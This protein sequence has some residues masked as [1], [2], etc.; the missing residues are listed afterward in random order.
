MNLEYVNHSGGA[1]GADKCWGETGKE[2]GVTSIHYYHGIKTPHGNRSLT[3]KEMEEGWIEVLEANKVLKR[4][5]AYYKSLLS[6]NW[7][8]V[9]Y[10]EAIYAI[11]TILRKQVVDGGTGWAVQMAINHSKPVFVFDQT[12]KGWYHYSY[13]ENKFI[14]LT[15]IPTLTNSYA[16]IGTRKLTK[17][18]EQAIQDTY[19]ITFHK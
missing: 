3:D 11:G 5:P 9:K 2:Y 19:K 6:R 13:I 17:L 4:N 15:T 1:E 12:L 18:G 14:N 16:G 8:P 7:F 10:S